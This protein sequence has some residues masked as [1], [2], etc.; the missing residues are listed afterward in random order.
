MKN[1]FTFLLFSAIIFFTSSCVEKPNPIPDLTPNTEKAVVL[2]EYSG[3]SCVP[4]A[5][6]HQTIANLQNTYGENLIVVTMHTFIGGQGNPVADSP[7]D[8]RSQVGQDILE[9]LGYPLGIPSGVVNRQL[10]AGEDDLQLSSTEWSG[11]IS[12]AL[13][14]ELLLGMSM[15][16]TFDEASR[17][18]DVELTMLPFGLIDGALKLTVLITE[19]HII[20]KQATPDGVID[21]YEHNHILR[22]SLTPALGEDIDNLALQSNLARTYSFTLPEADGSGPWVPENCKVVAYLS[23]NTGDSKEVLQAVEAEVVH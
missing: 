7:Y 2:E 21:D 16:T 18:L 19:S 22:T 12:D 13:K 4:C 1:I 23:R 20:N 3:G 8:F 6:A 14:E 10:F 17:Q 9:Y 11:R 5:T 15:E